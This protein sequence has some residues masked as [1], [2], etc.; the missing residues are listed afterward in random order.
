MT[1]AKLATDMPFPHITVPQLGGG[2]L[3]LGARAEG[4]DWKLVVVYRGKHCPLCTRYLQELEQALT[5]FHDIGVDVATVSADS[6][7]RATAQIAEVNPSFPVG[8]D[9]S[10]EQMREL[11]L[12][13]SGVRN[14]QDV[15]RPFAE[16]GLFVVNEEGKLQIIDISNAPFARPP[17]ASMLMGLR[18]YRGLKEEFP[19]NGSQAA[20]EAA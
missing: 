6:E 2:T 12:Y 11:G 10:M 5:E 20:L 3:D 7:E 13:I 1:S 4:Y 14:G 9:L 17:I 15:E 19:V 16:P 18:F 8:Y